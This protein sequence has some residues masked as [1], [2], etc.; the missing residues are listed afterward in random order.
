MD[1]EKITDLDEAMI[2]G[3]FETIR[4][5]FFTKL[6]LLTLH[7]GGKA[8]KINL[9]KELST[10][11]TK[12]FVG[13]SQYERFLTGRSPAIKQ[14][15]IDELMTSLVLSSWICFEQIVKDITRKDYSLHSNDISLDFHNRLLG[16]STQVKKDL[17]LFYYIRNSMVHYN[18][19]YY[20]YKTIDH[21][22]GGTKF[23]SKGHEGE[24]MDMPDMMI[25]FNIHND[26]QKYSFEGW[27]NAQK[28]KKQ[29]SKQ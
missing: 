26:I 24:K 15:L 13:F 1:I 20:A 23:S 4:S 8:L 21:T 2:I 5:N 25:A 27:T 19:A 18:G 12:T 10:E 3:Y 28:I 7:D 14:N 11:M 29:A 9:P 22:Y 6:I 17:D 16:F